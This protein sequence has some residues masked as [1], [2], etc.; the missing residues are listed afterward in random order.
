VFTEQGETMLSAVLRNKSA[1]EVSIKIVDSFV[2]MRRFISANNT[3]FQR[4]ETI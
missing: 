1:I 2:N 3:V 4:L